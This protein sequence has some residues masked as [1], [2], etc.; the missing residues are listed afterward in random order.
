MTSLQVYISYN[1]T[2]SWDDGDDDNGDDGSMTVLRV[3]R[4]VNM[5]LFL[6]YEFLNMYVTKFSSE[7]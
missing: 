1:S 2:F 3:P 4:L 6:A 5:V 7:E